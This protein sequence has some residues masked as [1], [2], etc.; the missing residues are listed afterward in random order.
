MVTTE[1]DAAFEIKRPFS[2][3]SEFTQ[4]CG[5]CGCVFRVEIERPLYHKDSQ[6]YCCPEC[7]H[8]VCVAKTSTLPRVTLISKRTDG[9]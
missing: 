1:T 4:T 8:H 6:E 3:N 7:K 2:P 9:G 5:S